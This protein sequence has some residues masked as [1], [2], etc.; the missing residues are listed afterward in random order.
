MTLQTDRPLLVALVAVAL[1]VLSVTAA[2]LAGS[3]HARGTVVAA[4]RALVQLALVSLAVRAVLEHLPLTVGFLLLMTVIATVTSARRLTPNRSGLVAGAAILAGVLP[5]LALLVGSGL[6]PLAGIALV[7]VGGIV[8]GAAMTGTTL[9][10]RRALGALEER[11]GEYEA[12]LAL[13]M[14]SRCAALEVVCPAA[15]DALLPALDQTRTV[16]LVTLPGTYVGM[17]LGGA[18]PL[19]AGVLQLVVLLSLLAAQS[20]ALWVTAEVV[21]RGL[22]HR[23]LNL[24]R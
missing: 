19:Q 9:A 7:P 20:L 6:V 23:G 2:H 14:S 10:G 3:P 12:G 24:P 11:R 17:L 5:V 8:V 13:G 16:G 22:V 18:S 21:A 1:V 15:S 4:V